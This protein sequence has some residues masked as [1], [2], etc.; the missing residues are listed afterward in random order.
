MK[1]QILT[2]GEESNRL[3]KSEKVLINQIKSVLDK[4]NDALDNGETDLSWQ[5]L[6]F[7]QRIQLKLDSE[8][9]L[10]FKR[11]A[12]YFEANKKLKSWRK[13]AVLDY[14][15][16]MNNDDKPVNTDALCEAYH[17]LHEH[18]NNIYTKNRSIL[19][20]LFT[21][22]LT[23]FV[24]LLLFLVVIWNYNITL[25]NDLTLTSQMP[26][27]VTFSVLLFG[28]MGACLSAIF[29]LAGGA[30]G[31]NIPKLQV[32]FWITLS[33]PVVGTI[34]ALVIYIFIVSGILFPNQ[35][36]NTA[37]ILSISFVAG[38]SERLIIRAVEAVTDDS[39][40]N[41]QSES[42]KS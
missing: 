42:Q 30:Q 32:N 40:L 25:D 7:P 39:K 9:A 21:L 1:Q 24:A 37:G 18:F 35:N 38:F 19:K 41:L 8:D 22:S 15:D 4:A 23:A 20:Q 6:H 11:N 3:T 31:I 28:I 34:S 27:S 2:E 5:L 16:D 36:L 12:L 26:L 33:R 13:E 14:L 29:S 17:I 10:L